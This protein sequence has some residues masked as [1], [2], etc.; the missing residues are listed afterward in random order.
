MRRTPYKLAF[1]ALIGYFSLQSVSAAPVSLDL[2]FGAGGYF[3]RD[4]S[5]A[6][7]DH[8]RSIIVQ[9]D[10]KSIVTGIC[11]T[12]TTLRV[13][14]MRLTRGGALDTAFGSGGIV[15]TSLDVSYSSYTVHA[16]L[17]DDGKIVLAH[18]CPVGEGNSR[19]CVARFTSSG[20][21]DSG[22]GTSGRVTITM[23]GG[24]QTSDA[25]AGVGVAANG[26]ITVGGS[27]QSN[28][29]PA[30]AAPRFCTARLT[31]GGVLDSAYGT[32]GR[33]FHTN[34]AWNAPSALAK[35]MLH[36]RSGSVW[37]AGNCFGSSASWPCVLAVARNGRIGTGFGNQGLLSPNIPDVNSS[38][39]AAL[40]SQRDGKILIG[41]TCNGSALNSREFCSTRV[42]A[43]TGELD[44]TFSAGF[45][46]S[47]VVRTSFPTMLRAH[48]TSFAIDSDGAILAS[49]RCFP[50][51]LTDD[52]TCAARYRPEGY[53]D[54]SFSPSGTM[55]APSAPLSF[56]YA[57]AIHPNGRILLAG[58]CR[59]STATTYDTCVVGLEGGPQTFSRCSLDV[60]GD[61]VIRPEVD[62]LIWARAMF[63]FD[64]LRVVGDITFPPAA[65][66][67]GWFAIREYLT[68]QCGMEVRS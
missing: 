21:L 68:T 31:T 46:L 25:P 54:T 42:S 23:S 37:L 56:A 52:V 50:S 65:T 39:V 20:A 2:E 47:G 34:A 8:A 4:L 17:A 43:S 59:S 6:R 16:A 41:A 11:E 49:G 66:R 62:G 18:A 14:M 7:S 48:L 12:D 67:N 24:V 28:D 64:I 33:A 30:G 36:Q 32:G 3:V 10:G 38:E 22:F 51:N 29:E 19:F 45:A 44:T 58:G 60:D 26:S 55:V 61:G 13:C 27:C 15:L 9:P 57:S 63:G 53:L 1:L 5:I 40:A 35:T